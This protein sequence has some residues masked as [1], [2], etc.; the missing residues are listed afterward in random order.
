[1]NNKQMAESI[2]AILE[3]TEGYYF[4]AAAFSLKLLPPVFSNLAN[5]T[6]PTSGRGKIGV[7][8]HY[9]LHEKHP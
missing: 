3:T 1:M 4:F 6:R 7:T 8:T 2:A 9:V 5:Y